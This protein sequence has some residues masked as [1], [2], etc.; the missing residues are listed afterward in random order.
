MSKIR[1]IFRASS[2]MEKAQNDPEVKRWQGAAF[3]GVGPYF[4]N[5]VVGTGLTFAE[6]RLLLPNYLGV[7]VDDKQFRAKIETEYHSMFTNVPEDGL[8]LETG[9]ENDDEELSVGNMPLVIK[10][11]IVWRHIIASPEVAKNE[12]EAS[13]YQHYRYFIHDPEAITEGNIALAKLAD[14][15]MHLYFKYKDDE[16]KVDQILTL[17]GARTEK[18]SFSEKQINLRSLATPKHGENEYMQS[19]TLKRFIRIANDKDREMKFLIKELV[20]LQYLRQVG[21]QGFVFYETGVKVGDSMEEA[22]L[23]F[24]NP[25]NSK[26]L[27]LAKAHY[28]TRSKR[29]N[30]EELISKDTE[31]VIS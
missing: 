31:T 19:E 13:R 3:R 25:K 7:E 15:A 9:L 5:K 14:E 18:M 21:A 30:K 17:M 1:K 11:Y 27:N 16:I 26:E 2:F 6:Q 24:T 29:A 22:V 4:E 28:V 20:G 12:Q 10:D 8:V 23:Y